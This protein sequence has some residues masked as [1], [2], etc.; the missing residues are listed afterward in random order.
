[1]TEAIRVALLISSDKGAKGEREDLSGPAIA[2]KLQGLAEVVATAIVADNKDLI[3][4]KLIY[5]ADR[6][7]VDI[8]FTSGGTGLAPRDVTP[9]ATLL[10]CERIV[11]GITDAMRLKSFEVTDRAMLSRAVAGTRGKTLIINLPGSPKAVKECLDVFLPVI[12]HA[13]ETLRGEAYE[14]AR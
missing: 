7:K 2:E 3:L 12:E 11:P 8:V 13:V 10:A 6:L 1:M 5:F 9:E 14:C 4:E